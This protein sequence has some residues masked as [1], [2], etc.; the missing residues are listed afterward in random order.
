VIEFPV[1]HPPKGYVRCWI[2][3]KVIQRVKI[4]PH[5]K[6]THPR[7]KR[8]QR[9]TSKPTIERTPS[10]SPALS[11]KELHVSERRKSLK[12]EIRGKVKLVAEPRLKTIECPFCLVPVPEPEVDEHRERYHAEFLREQLRTSQIL[13]LPFEL[14]PSGGNGVSELR[15]YYD[16]WLRRCARNGRQPEFD[17]SRIEQIET[18]KPITRRVGSRKWHGYAVFEFDRSE[19][20]ILEC[21]VSGNATLHS[22]WRLDE[23]NNETKS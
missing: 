8:A 1:P 15:S 10:T 3:G 2:C 9:G 20:V 19:R 21:P 6:Q 17:W 4:V 13:Q 22:F 16:G 18:L 23:P 14:L 11:Q 12:R 5:L 7:E